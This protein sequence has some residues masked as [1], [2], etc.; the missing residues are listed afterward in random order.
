MANSLNFN[1]ANYYSFK[2]FPM[3]AY[4]MKFKNL[5]ANLTILGSH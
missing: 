5:F 4:M 1:F 2:N 3:T